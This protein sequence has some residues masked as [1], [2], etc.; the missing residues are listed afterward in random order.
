LVP[1][2]L[3]RQLCSIVGERNSELS[4]YASAGDSTRIIADIQRAISEMKNRLL[5]REC[6]QSSFAHYPS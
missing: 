6:A 2:T 5:L 3:S 1:F 4:K